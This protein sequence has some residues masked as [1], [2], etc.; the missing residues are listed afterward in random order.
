MRSAKSIWRSRV[1]NVSNIVLNS[2]F[3]GSKI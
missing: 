1:E 3:W 2:Y